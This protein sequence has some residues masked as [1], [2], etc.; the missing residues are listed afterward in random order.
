[1]KNRQLGSILLI[2]G[3]SIGAG[4]LGIP[5]VT[6]GAGFI[7]SAL[8][9]FLAWAFMALSG[10]VLSE[11]V[12][13]YRETNVNL[14]TMAKDCLGESGR[15]VVSLLFISLFYALMVAYILAAGMLISHHLPISPSIAS[16]LT[17]S[18][19]Y[20][21]IA[22][23]LKLVDAFNRKLMMG[24]VASYIFLVIFGVPEVSADRLLSYDFNAVWVALPILVVSFGYH[25][26]VPSLASYVGRSR[27][28]LARSIVIGSLIPLAIYLV[29]EF[30]I[31]GIVPFDSLATWKVAKN[32]GE[33]ITEV[34]CQNAPQSAVAITSETFAFFAI[35]TSFLPVAFS[36]FDFLRDGFRFRK[37][38]ESYLALL[39][40]LP[41]LVLSLVNPTLFLEALDFAGGFCAV[42]LFGILPSL[43]VY[44]RKQRI[45]S[46]HFAIAKTPVLLF[47]LVGSSGILAIELFHMMGVL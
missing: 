25:N 45:G 42:I 19:I 4:M 17:V 18:G 12:L 47:L 7:P 34:L 22:K 29:W 16:I 41:P 10:L 38:K 30:V 8:F 31:L 43:M 1:M 33:M 9:F 40:L 15:F 37:V 23:G 32:G 5:V 11:L 36:F 14:L 26:L 21:A 46:A 3:C 35:A 20:F 39:V 6:G 2:A 13:S 27:K 28:I 24:L 44:K